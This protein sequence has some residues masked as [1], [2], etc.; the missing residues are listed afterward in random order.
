MPYFH[1][2]VFFRKSFG[3]TKTENVYNTICDKIAELNNIRGYNKN[4]VIA[5]RWDN[6]ISLK[7]A[8]GSVARPSPSEF[9]LHCR[10][11]G[12]AVY[13]QEIRAWTGGFSYQRAVGKGINPNDV[14]EYKYNEGK[15]VP[16]MNRPNLLTEV[17]L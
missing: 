9:L 15:A 1:K 12:P 17:G 8:D 2:S 11:E 4:Y 5:E 10:Y 7:K 6:E 16:F 3:T 14:M 13:K